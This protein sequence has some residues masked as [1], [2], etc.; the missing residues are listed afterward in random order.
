MK[1]VTIIGASHGVGAAMTA[2]FHA[3]G[4][5]ITAVARHADAL[6]EL[7]AHHPGITILARDAGDPTTAQ[8]LLR[9]QP[10]I[11]VLAAGTATPNMPFQDLDWDRFSQNWTGDLQ[12][13][14]HLLKAALILP[15]KPGAVVIVVTSGAGLA[16][17]PVSG[18]YAGA[19]RMQMF[20]SGYAQKEAQ[21]L[22]RDTR[23]FGLMPKSI[24]TETRFGRAAVDAYLARLGIDEAA[25]FSGQEARQTPDQVAQ[26]ALALT[27][28]PA[29]YD[30]VNYIAGASGI[31]LLP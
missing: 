25:F 4:D 16:G 27:G 9:H 23:F 20:L 14:F 5:R 17:S 13:T 6:N 1:N 3:R 22:G 31:T 30:G 19:K 2:A 12:M 21:R 29:S 18:G 7:A 28:D 8:E 15:M 24:M 10:D 26:A 11:V